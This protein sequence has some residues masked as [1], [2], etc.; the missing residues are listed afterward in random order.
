MKQLKSSQIIKK[1]QI[2]LKHYIQV[3]SNSQFQYKW[4]PLKNDKKSITKHL[5]PQIEITAVERKNEAWQN[6]KM[7]IARYR[8]EKWL[9]SV[10]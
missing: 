7:H 8:W 6:E 4:D 10:Q 2:A 9:L 5:K 3:S 1:P